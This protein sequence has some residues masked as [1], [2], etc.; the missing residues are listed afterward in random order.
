MCCPSSRT[1]GRS[2]WT[3][4]PCGFAS[5]A[6]RPKPKTASPKRALRRALELSPNLY[7]AQTSLIS[8]LWV[9]S[10]LDE[11]AVILKSSADASACQAFPS[12]TLGLYYEQQKLDAEAEKYLKIG[13]SAHEYESALA[14]AGF[15]A[16]RERF[17]EA[18]AVSSH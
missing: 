17:A 13:A 3:S 9:T 1:H 11:G 14:L 4:S 10:R 12:R 16:R 8:L 15:Y 7:E 6:L 5:G 2:S 18:L